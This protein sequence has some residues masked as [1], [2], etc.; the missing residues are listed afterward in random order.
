[1]NGNNGSGFSSQILGNVNS[2]IDMAGMLENMAVQLREDAK[3][4][5]IK[6]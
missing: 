4:A 5:R 2:I 3:R 6:K 1:M